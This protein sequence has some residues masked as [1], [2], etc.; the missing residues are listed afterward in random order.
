MRVTSG[1]A[2]VV[3]DCDS[4]LA[5]I[6]GIDELAGPHAAQIAALTE[7]A[8]QGTVALEEVY[9]RRLEI[10]RPTRAQVEAIG[11]AYV[12][13]LV[14]DAREVIAALLW[15]GKTVRIL[16][17]GLRTAVDEVARAVGL[18]LEMVT[19]VG[20]EFAEDGSYAGFET[21]SPVARSG[22]K[23]E[24]IRGWHLPRPA[25]LVG[26]GATDLEARPAVDAFAAYMGVA[27][28]PAVAAGADFVLRGRSLAPVLS[29]AATEEDRER[30]AGSEW[31]GLL[32][33]GDA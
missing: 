21:T 8:M 20:L 32:G 12:D 26:D 5:A 6:E 15:L 11:R 3:F 14:P 10:I 23:T 4:T 17:G 31:A 9:G 30:L 25:L 28:R 29:L 19:A 2:S 1:F 27:F 13:A 18:P 7:A 33:R 24:V 22:G 16:S